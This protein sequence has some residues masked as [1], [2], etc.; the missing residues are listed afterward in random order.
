[1][2]EQ[3]SLQMLARARLALFQTICLPTMVVQTTQHFFWLI[4]VDPALD[5]AVLSALLDLVSPYENIYIVPSNV[6]FRINQDFPGAWRDGAEIDSLQQH[7]VYNAHHCNM[8]YLYLSMAL[9]SHLPILETRLDADDGLQRNFLHSIQQEALQLF[10]E[11]TSPTR[12]MYWCSR[13]HLEWHWSLHGNRVGRLEG[14]THDH[15]CVTPGLTTGF[16]AGISEASVPVYPHH[17]AAKHLL[18]DSSCSSTGG[19]CLRWANDKA[20]A[21]VRSRT[22]TSAGMA[23][24]LLGDEDIDDEE[25]HWVQYIMWNAMHE[26][27]GLERPQL[28]WMNDY[29]RKNLVAIAKDNLMGQCTTGHSCKESAQADLERIIAMHSKLNA[30]DREEIDSQAGE[31]AA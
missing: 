28:A 22:P 4:Q 21:A 13:R 30:T 14:I 20:F 3:G 26:M 8:P 18:G 16:A 2:Q 9:E 25:E 7:G 27:F 5:A 1:M 29:L 10:S 19:P 11:S 31:S 15:L 23:D 6:N 17:E 12:W 24:V